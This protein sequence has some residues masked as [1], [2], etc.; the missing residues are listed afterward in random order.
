[1]RSSSLALL[2]LALS[3]AGCSLAPTLAPPAPPSSPTAA[4]PPPSHAPALP[5]VALETDVRFRDVTLNGDAWRPA[6]LLVLNQ[7]RAAEDIWTGTPYLFGGTSRHGIDCSAFVQRVFADDFG[8]ALPRS[9]HAQVLEG[10]AVR[11]DELQPGDLVFFRLGRQQHVGI[12]L[13]DGQFL[14][15]STSRG[16]TRDRLDA[17][18]YARGFWTARRV[19]TPE[20]I[21]ALTPAVPPTL[22]LS[23]LTSEPRSPAA[24]PPAPVRQGPPPPPPGARITER[25]FPDTPATRRSGW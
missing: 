15:A 5:D 17:P 7:L 13:Y 14:H 12:Y 2:A 1:M 25:S 8:I 11:R 24:R 22:A 19:L 6:E 20:R 9:T 23:D 18:Y 21:A 10:R 3:L 4:T 16:V